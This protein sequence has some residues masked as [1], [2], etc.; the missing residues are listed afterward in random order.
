MT[1]VVRGGIRCS[2]EE[3]SSSYIHTSERDIKVLPLWKAMIVSASQSPDI[4]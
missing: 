3:D 1:V 4:T 2:F